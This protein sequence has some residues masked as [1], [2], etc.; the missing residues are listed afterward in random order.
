MSRTKSSRHILIKKGKKGR[1][2]F[3]IDEF[4]FVIFVFVFLL[5]LPNSRGR[6]RKPLSKNNFVLQN[7]VKMRVKLKYKNTHPSL[8]SLVIPYYNFNSRH[9]PALLLNIIL[10]EFQ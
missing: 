6:R 10:K 5:D 9:F 1:K 4:V 3:K 2:P 7:S 8:R